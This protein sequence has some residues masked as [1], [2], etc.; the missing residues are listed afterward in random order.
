MTY[1][2]YK[3]SSKSMVHF[4]FVRKRGNNNAHHRI[5]LIREGHKNIQTFYGEGVWRCGRQAWRSR[6]AIT[7]RI[8]V[9]LDYKK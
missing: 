8:L 2:I 6:E 4:T 9:T 5:M 7:H 1:V 3:Q